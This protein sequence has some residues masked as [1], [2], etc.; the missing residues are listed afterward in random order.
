MFS[1]PFAFYTVTIL[2]YHTT[3]PHM[4]IICERIRKSLFFAMIL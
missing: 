2:L 1:T 4:R 3:L